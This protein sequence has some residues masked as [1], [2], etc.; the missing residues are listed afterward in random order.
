MILN[1]LFQRET[2]VEST[3]P[4]A[5]ATR[6]K[7]FVGESFFSTKTSQRVRRKN[8]GM[9]KMA[10]GV[11]SEQ[12]RKA[13]KARTV[14]D[15]DE[16][17]EDRPFP[18]LP[19]MP[20]TVRGIEKSRTISDFASKLKFGI[21]VFCLIAGSAESFERPPPEFQP[22]YNRRPFPDSTTTSE[23]PISRSLV[24][25]KCS[26]DS[27]CTGEQICYFPITGKQL[28]S[29][30]QLPEKPLVKIFY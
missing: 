27:D 8:T 28:L 15:D 20:T 6:K 29:G 24:Y 19:G 14:D 21:F 30:F 18:G 26:D 25:P 22:H 13:V 4:A 9:G 7:P 1:L 2:V 16:E 5:A 17:E 23:V 3:Q 10:V 11:G 12:R